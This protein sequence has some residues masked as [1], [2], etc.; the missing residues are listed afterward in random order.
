MIVNK[1]NPE[2]TWTS[3]KKYT[4]HMDLINVLYQDNSDTSIHERAISNHDKLQLLYRQRLSR[5][6]HN[7]IISDGFRSYMYCYRLNKKNQP[8]LCQKI[9]L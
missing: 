2:T 4:E 8:L 6:K 5:R 7:F 9:M 1:F 3:R